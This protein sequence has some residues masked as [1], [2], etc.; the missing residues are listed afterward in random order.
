MDYD[1]IFIVE[2]VL[3]HVKTIFILSVQ[4]WLKLLQFCKMQTLQWCSSV[5]LEGAITSSPLTCQPKCRIR[6]VPCF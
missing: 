1:I 4:H 3:H 2:G 5:G 6:E